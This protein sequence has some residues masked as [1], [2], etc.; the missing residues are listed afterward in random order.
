MLSKPEADLGPIEQVNRDAVKLY[1]DE[2][3]T[4]VERVVSRFPDG[5][6]TWYGVLEKFMTGEWS[7]LIRKR[8]DGS[9]GMVGAAVTYRDMSGRAVV[10]IVFISG[11]PLEEV[12]RALEMVEK[13]CRET[14]VEVLEFWG[15]DGWARALD[16]F[17]KVTRLYRKRV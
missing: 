16:G 9:I 4:F 5:H 1:A 8:K 6:I 17:E 7:C 3:R 11:G 12:K 10:Q 13:T 14:G 2:L 15:R